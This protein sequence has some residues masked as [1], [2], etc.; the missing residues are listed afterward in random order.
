MFWRTPDPMDV[1]INDIVENIMT[2]PLPPDTEGRL[3]LLKELEDIRA[4]RPKTLDPNTML[5]VGG[6]LA[7]L[8]IVVAYEQRHVLT[9]SALRFLTAFKP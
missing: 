8:V 9:S 4:K 6:N 3:H 7:G 1:L 2:Q 5:I